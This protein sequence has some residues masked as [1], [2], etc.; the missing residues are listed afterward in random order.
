MKKELIAIAIILSMSIAYGCSL[1]V[2]ETYKYGDEVVFVDGFYKG[3][4]G[5]V[6]RYMYSNKYEVDIKNVGTKDHIHAST[7]ELKYKIK[8]DEVKVLMDNSLR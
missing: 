3:Q 6:K 5:V 2:T 7:M 4:A 8:L 1:T